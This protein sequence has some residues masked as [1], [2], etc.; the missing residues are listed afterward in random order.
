MFS[1][2]DECP[3]TGGDGVFLARALLF[4]YRDTLILQ[5][6]GECQQANPAESDTAA[7]PLVLGVYPNP[8]IDKVHIWA[9]DLKQQGVVQVVD[10]MG[11]MFIQQSVEAGVAFLELNT[12]QL[13][14][15]MYV[16]SLI[17]DGE[18]SRKTM[19]LKQ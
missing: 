3:S 12:S 10:L 14:P 2:A 16:I 4:A 5:D 1:I 19:W 6:D 8:G 18:V 9:A 11:R 13:N 17:S 15:G 7:F